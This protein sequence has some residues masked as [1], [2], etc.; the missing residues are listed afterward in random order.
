MTVT[1]CIA[2]HPGQIWTQTFKEADFIHLMSY[3]SCAGAPCRHAT[4]DSAKEHVTAMLKGGIP[5][6][7]LLLGIPAYAREMN[8]PQE[9]KTY[10]EIYRLGALCGT[11]VTCG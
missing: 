7:K 8:H 10:E 1:V 11:P 6:S 4:L 5:A 3:D 9:V 2:V